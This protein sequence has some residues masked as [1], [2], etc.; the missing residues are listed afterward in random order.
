MR[1]HEHRKGSITH[2][3]L[4][5]GTRGRTARGWELGK[6]NMGEMSDIGDGEEGSK[7]HCRVCTYVIILQVLRMYLKT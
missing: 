1:T 7:P 3:S 6:D 2:W 5:A 4:L